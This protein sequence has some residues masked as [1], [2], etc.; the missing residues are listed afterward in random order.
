MMRKYYAS[1]ARWRQAWR[2]RRR[3][4]LRRRRLRVWHF[5]AGAC[6]D[7]AR[8]RAGAAPGLDSAQ[9]CGKLEVSMT[10]ST[11]ATRD[12]TELRTEVWNMRLDVKMSVRYTKI[13]HDRK[14]AL[15]IACSILIPF[16]GSGTVAVWL[17]A[18]GYSWIYALIGILVAALSVLQTALKLGE[19]I[20]KL[21]ELTT[22]WME[23]ERQWD[24]LWSRFDHESPAVLRSEVKRL[25]SVKDQL[26]GKEGE[27]RRRPG[28]IK[29]VQVAVRK[30]EGL[31]ASSL[32]D[33]S[34][35][36]PLSQDPPT[37]ALPQRATPSYEDA[38]N[39]GRDT[40][41]GAG[42]KEP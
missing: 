9:D 8:K 38:Q 37:V 33:E 2:R 27:F 28:L 11:P 35:P 30:A 24:D 18:N 26:D 32:P 4:R 23:Q 16:L 10:T 15:Q 25:R 20:P 6:I 39:R 21:R 14:S 5:R 36:R 29:R 13:L 42:S 3:R 22:A 17:F 34:E 1:L 12:A 19:S 7:P 31:V 40:V 41:N